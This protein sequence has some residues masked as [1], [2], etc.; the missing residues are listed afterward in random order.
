LL[1]A[2]LRMPFTFRRPADEAPEAGSREEAR[3]PADRSWPL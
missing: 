3:D 1:A 2:G